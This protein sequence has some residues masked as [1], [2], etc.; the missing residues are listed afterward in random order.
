MARKTSRKPVRKI[1]KK[2]TA[3]R[4][5]VAKKK[6]ARKKAGKAPVTTGP[7]SKE[8][9]TANPYADEPPSSPLRG[10]TIPPPAS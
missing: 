6:P 3:K 1:R 2:T 7:V 5:A 10:E 4:K 8:V 9:P